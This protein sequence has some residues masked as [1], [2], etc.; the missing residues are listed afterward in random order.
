MATSPLSQW[1]CR[2]VYATTLTVRAYIPRWTSLEFSDQLSDTG[3]GKITFDYNDTFIDSFDLQY[4]DGVLFDGSHAIQ[5]LRNGVLAFTFLI[6][7][8]SV[9][10]A[11]TNQ[12]TVIAGRGIAGQLDWAIVLPE[13]YSDSMATVSLETG[14]QQLLP[15]ELRGY[16]FLARSATTTNLAAT[17]STLFSGFG[18][19]RASAN[20]FFPNVDGITD[21]S[22]HDSILVKDQ[23][24]TAHNGIYLIEDIGSLS[25]RWVLTRIYALN[26][27]EER[28]VYI[29]ARAWVEEGTTNGQKAFQMTACP[30]S[31]A[32]FGVVPITFALATS[33]YTAVSGFYILF[34]EADTGNELNM[35]QGAAWGDVRSGYGR[36][37]I[38]N[39]VSWAL[40]LDSALTTSE[41]LT[42]SKGG[43]PKDG[44]NVTIEYG[45]TLLEAI[46]S[47]CD[48]TECHWHVSPSGVVSI[49]RKPNNLYTV[50]FGIDRSTGTSALMF[51]L[52]LSNSSQTK[53]SSRDMRS[54]VFAS[55][56]FLIDT[57]ESASI[58]A[59]HGRREG[60]YS[61]TASDG[62]AVTNTASTGLRKAAGLT[63]GI[64]IDFTETSGRQAFIDFQV[65]DKVLIEYNVGSYDSR[66]VS[67]ISVSIGSDMTTSIQ[68]SFEMVIPDALVDLQNQSIYG[69]SQGSRLKAFASAGNER[70]SAPA[71][72]SAPVSS[73]EGL[74][75]RVNVSWNLS[76]SAGASGY[77]VYVYRTDSLGRVSSATRT[78]N[79]TTI[80]TP[81]PHGL[82]VN[83]IVTVTMVS[84]NTTY[85]ITNAVVTAVSTTGITNQSFSYAQTGTSSSSGTLFDESRFDGGIRLSSYSRKAN[86]CTLITQNFH[87]LS[88]GQK[89]IVE[90][91]GDASID[92]F[93]I[94][95]LTTPSVFDPSQIITFASPGPDI[96]D[97]SVSL[98]TA[99]LIVES[100]STRVAAFQTSATVEGLATSGRPYFT[101]V[102]SLN[103]NGE[104]GGSTAPSTFFSSGGG[105]NG[106]AV[107]AYALQVVGGAIKSPNYIAGN[108]GWIIRNDGSSEFGSATIRGN[109][110]AGNIDIGSGSTSFHVD[111]VGNHWSG[112]ASY[113]SAPFKVSNTGA[114]IATNVNIS[115]TLT[116]GTGTYIVEMGSDVGPSTGHYGISLSP[117]N[118]DDIFIKRNDGV[119]FFR[120]NSGGTNSLTFD[121]LS[122]VL[123]I[124]G[125]VTASSGTIANWTI[126]S[127]G[128]QNTSGIRTVNLYPAAGTTSDAVLN[129]KYGTSRCATTAGGVIIYEADPELVY[130]WL[131]ASGLYMRDGYVDGK[132]YLM[133]SAAT[134]DSTDT[135][136]RDAGT[137]R[138]YIKNS[139]RDLKENISNIGNSLDTLEKLSPV[140]FNWKITDEDKENDI[141]YK[142]LTKQTYKTMGF[143]LEEVQEISPE[144]VTW[145]KKE[146]GS[147]YPG[148]WKT[149]D[150][151]ALAIQ[152]IKDLNKKVSDLELQ[153]SNLKG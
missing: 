42:D 100:Q 87:G 33:V 121:S 143:I 82:Q 12:E 30:T 138:I 123:A 74:S 113:A 142:M 152:G 83:D 96:T 110:T 24:N 23:T 139:S 146:D 129:I 99:K 149:D 67:G 62:E 145:R 38:V 44:G 81:E 37:G 108:T 9:Q 77:E 65:G 140:S 95:I 39:K 131:N 46:G 103:A 90:N 137:G 134:S 124:K 105:I 93:N 72:K 50:P 34:K 151:I 84:P 60:Y 130:T 28:N 25:T 75:N 86:I 17:Y 153:L 58:K 117:D 1:D 73:V 13:N 144:L 35:Q 47:I 92:G 55:N 57:K 98:A 114:L 31:D 80:V 43:K 10:R 102:I 116:S 59:T 15:R 8:V 56:S 78:A 125:D 26:N 49:A 36:G 48:Q 141:E 45:K 97:T 5:V 63:F 54:I 150:F 85:S 61:N 126:N 136:V 21:Y 109:L 32:G 118:F 69:T 29:G 40:S 119:K 19:L 135:C 2:V 76:S 115:G 94:V 88:P 106:Q 91:T 133:S 71:I 52:P 79:V 64:D 107:D 68:L 147:L 120:I 127:S 66:I 6:E 14:G 22:I 16:E 70:V 128:L 20:G 104:Y 112:N 132:Y 101:K 18:Q 148:Y 3:S 7:D 53:T 41:G 51:P 4:G 122:G 89:I 111:S 11:G 27:Y